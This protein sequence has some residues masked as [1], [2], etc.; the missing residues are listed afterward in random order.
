M[1]LTSVFHFLYVNREAVIS[2]AEV[3]IVLI[4]IRIIFIYYYFEQ[5]IN[6]VSY[7]AATKK[8]ITQNKVSVMEL[9]EALTVGFSYN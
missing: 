5:L 6:T 2:Y 3:Y 4:L 1:R 9:L 8:T 7:L